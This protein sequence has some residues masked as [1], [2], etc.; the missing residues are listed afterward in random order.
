[1]SGIRS[2]D[3]SGGG[4]LSAGHN[5][6]GVARSQSLPN[7]SSMFSLPFPTRISENI[8]RR[9]MRRHRTRRRLWSLTS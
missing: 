1:M 2:V 8:E 4:A 9:S 3:V 7:F 6:S 5:L